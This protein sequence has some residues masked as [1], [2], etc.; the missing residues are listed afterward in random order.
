MHWAWQPFWAV[1]EGEWKLISLG[2]KGLRNQQQLVNL[3][4]PEPERKNYIKDKPEIA[5]RLQSLHD[6]WVKE[7]KYVSPW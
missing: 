6:A 2:R 4:D 5:D 7:T 3:N 1:S